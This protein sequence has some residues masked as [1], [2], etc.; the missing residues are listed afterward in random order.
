M[1]S[2]AAFDRLH[3]RDGK[4]H[5]ER[6][7]E[8]AQCQLCGFMSQRQGLKQHQSRKICVLGAV[9]PRIKNERKEV[10]KHTG[11]V[12]EPRVPRGRLT[13]LKR[14]NRTRQ[15]ITTSDGHVLV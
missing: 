1:Q 11:V 6:T 4:T 9:A 14:N 15:P 12:N 7:L 13:Q 8:K 3:K 10:V 5:R 2:K